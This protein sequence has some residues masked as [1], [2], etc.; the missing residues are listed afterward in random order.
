MLT[1]TAFFQISALEKLHISGVI[2]QLLACMIH[3]AHWELER[4]VSC[5]ELLANERQGAPSSLSLCII[6]KPA[7]RQSSCIVDF[8]QEHHTVIIMTICF[9]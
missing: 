6:R 1:C 5:A 4:I 9:D 7:P 2:C 8:N 3:H